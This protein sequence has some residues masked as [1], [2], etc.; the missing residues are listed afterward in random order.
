MID[1][2]LRVR[3]EKIRTFANARNLLSHAT[4]F[5][6]RLRVLSAP[7]RP[8]LGK[9]VNNSDCPIELLHSLACEVLQTA[10]EAASTERVSRHFSWW[11]NLMEFNCG[12][13]HIHVRTLEIGMSLLTY[14][15]S[16]NWTTIVKFL[17]PSHWSL[18]FADGINLTC[19]LSQTPL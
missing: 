18:P 11:M 15:R 10:A 13:L 16:S 2:F 19:D 12:V 17:S 8:S 1:I 9:N 14:L 5:R 6:V 3:R 7:R 4:A